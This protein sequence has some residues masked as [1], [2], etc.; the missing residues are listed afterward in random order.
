MEIKP[1]GDNNGSQII[2]SF[3]TYL[4][5]IFYIVLCQVCINKIKKT[6]FQFLSD[7]KPDKISRNKIIKDYGHGGLKMLDVKIYPIS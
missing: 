6:L 4:S 5:T 1:V 3:K 7:N 2:Y